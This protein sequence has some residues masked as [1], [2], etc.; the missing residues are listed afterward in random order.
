MAVGVGGVSPIKEDFCQ[1]KRR[2]T[3]LANVKRCPLE[4][5]FPHVEMS[6]KDFIV[7]FKVIGLIHT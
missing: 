7:R 2:A 6:N 4:Y 5:N 3:E 1:Q